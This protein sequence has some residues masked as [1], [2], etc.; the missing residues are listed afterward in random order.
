M[1]IKNTINSPSAPPFFSVVISTYNRKDLLPRALASLFKQ[2]ESDWETIIVNDGS[3]D[4]TEKQISSYIEPS[5]KVF[6]I[7]QKHL[8]SIAAKNAGIKLSKGKFVTF[9]DSDDEYDPSHLRSRKEILENNS[10]V[11]FLHGGVKIIGNAYVPD[12]FN[13]TKMIHL[14]DCVIGGTFFIERKFILELNGFRGNSYGY[15]AELMDRAVDAKAIIQK[16][17]LPTY[18]YHREI[19]DS[20]SHSVSINHKT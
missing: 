2:T 14:K 7:K 17:N 3:T 20:I 8:G 9:L 11:V 4:N 1:N 18:I 15:D 13:P 19:Q 16:T 12:R 5:T 10:G 6:Y